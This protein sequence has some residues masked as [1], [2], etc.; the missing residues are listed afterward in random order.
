M[1]ARKRKGGKSVGDFDDTIAVVY[2]ADQGT[3]RSGHRPK[4]T[5]VSRAALGSTSQQSGSTTPPI[6]NNPLPVPEW[7]TGDDPNITVT[8]IEP[9]NAGPGTS[10][11][12]VSHH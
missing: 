9:G 6:S 3:S 12:S 5:L 10:A 2:N 8:Q 11:T 7:G 4:K 1:P